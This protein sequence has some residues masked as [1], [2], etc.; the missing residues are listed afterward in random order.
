MAEVPAPK[1]WRIESKM[2]LTRKFL[3]AMGIESDK[4]DEIIA[5]HAETVDGLK[6]QL[7]QYIADAEKLP[8]VQR[9]LEKAKEAAKN[10]GDAAKIQKAFDEYKAEVEERETKAAKEAALRK[11]AK[12]AGLTEAGIAKAVKY[13]DWSTIELTDKGDVKNAKDLIKSLR[14]EWPEHIAK[15]QQEGANTATPPANN[16]SG[17]KTREEIMKIKDTTERQAAW[18][19]YLKAQAQGNA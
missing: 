14:E 1:N 6:E 12:D 9:E 13:A 16:S 15:T 8:E 10:S 7:K 18:G 5:A 17:V 2:S 4:I 19:A 3:S 11:I